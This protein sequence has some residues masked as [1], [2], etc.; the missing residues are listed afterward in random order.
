[1]HTIYTEEIKYNK[2]K[3]I[4][5]IFDYDENLIRLIKTIPVKDT[6][7][8]HKILVIQGTCTSFTLF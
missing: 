2:E 8:V 3:R 5:F 6:Y 7:I 4:R 1:M